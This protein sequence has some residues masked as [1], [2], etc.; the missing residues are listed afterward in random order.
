[1]KFNAS[2]DL[3]VYIHDDSKVELF[4][5]GWAKT[6]VIL[7]SDVINNTDIWQTMCKEYLLPGEITKIQNN[8]SKYAVLY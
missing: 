2:A 6:I 5:V 1:M 8:L 4:F 7:K 3:K